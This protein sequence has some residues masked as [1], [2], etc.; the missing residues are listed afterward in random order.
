MECH[1]IRQFRG[2]TSCMAILLVWLFSAGIFCVNSISYTHPIQISYIFKHLYHTGSEFEFKSG[3][4][5]LPI[6]SVIFCQLFRLDLPYKKF[7]RF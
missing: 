6:F 1:V 2:F 3:N 7:L 4:C 5:P